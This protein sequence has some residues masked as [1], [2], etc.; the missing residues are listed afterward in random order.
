MPTDISSISIHKG[1]IWVLYEDGLDLGV[2]VTH[3]NQEF[4]AN[5]D[6]WFKELHLKS[7]NSEL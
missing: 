2:G 3:E 5:Y 4:D 6:F 1:L 7:V